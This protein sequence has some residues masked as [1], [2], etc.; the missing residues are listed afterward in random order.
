MSGS[1]TRGRPLVLLVAA[2]V[3]AAASL[4][5]LAPPDACLANAVVGGCASAGGVVEFLTKP[6][7]D[8]DL[9]ASYSVS[10]LRVPYRPRS[11]TDTLGTR[12]E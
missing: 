10:V 9:L 4:V 1:L 11:T 7:V 2:L 3:P 5:Q 12:D 8:Q 6:F